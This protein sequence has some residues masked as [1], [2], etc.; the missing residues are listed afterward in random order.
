V[1]LTKSIHFVCISLVYCGVDWSAEENGYGRRNDEDA[2]R[3]TRENRIPA[4][5]FPNE[6]ETI[7]VSTRPAVV[8]SVEYFVNCLTFEA[9]DK[10][11]KYSS[12]DL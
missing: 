1:R 10:A 5:E 3:T 7:L 4:T 8:E 11:G 12:D 2:R 6:F 9:S